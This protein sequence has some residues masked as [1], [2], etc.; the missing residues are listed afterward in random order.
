MLATW[1]SRSV[2]TNDVYIYP[3]TIRSDTIQQRAECC[4][5]YT[6]HIRKH[7][8]TQRVV[9]C[10]KQHESRV[11]SSVILFCCFSLSL[12]APPRTHA[13]QSCENQSTTFQMV[14]SLS[15]W[16]H[17]KLSNKNFCSGFSCLDP[18]CDRNQGKHRRRWKW[19]KN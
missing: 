5:L 15:I 19:R 2:Y 7:R 4:S 13:L 3:C 10:S 6:Q 18:S 17:E 1:N 14:T 16:P 12:S 8:Q 9:L 11:F